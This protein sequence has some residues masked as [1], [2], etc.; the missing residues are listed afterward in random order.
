[1]AVSSYGTLHTSKYGIETLDATLV[2][3]SATTDL[4]VFAVDVDNSRNSE[5]AYVKLWKP[6]SG[7][8]TV[9][10]TAPDFILRVSAG[11]VKTFLLAGATGHPAA[12]GGTWY[13]AC[14]D[15]GGTPGTTAMPNPVDVNVYTN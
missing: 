9:G 8:P 12:S 13:A 14:V 2:Q 4:T 7:T 5:D 6:A 11:E 15:T 1:M 3:V 10:T